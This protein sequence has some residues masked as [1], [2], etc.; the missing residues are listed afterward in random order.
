MKYS[1]LERTRQNCAVTC[2][3]MPQCGYFGV[4]ENKDHFGGNNPFFCAFYEYETGAPG[5]EAPDYNC[6]EMM[7]G[8]NWEHEGHCASGHMFG[9]T[10]SKNEKEAD[11]LYTC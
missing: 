7:R 9:F 4:R 10:S 6:Y 2:Q 11:S 5:K 8:F 1:K 3:K